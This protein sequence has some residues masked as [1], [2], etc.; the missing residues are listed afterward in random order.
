VD[1]GDGTERGDEG[2]E[3]KMTVQTLD[4]IH[5]KGYRLRNITATNRNGMTS[6]PVG[7]ALFERRGAFF[8]SIIYERFGTFLYATPEKQ[9]REV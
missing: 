4:D 3:R 9:E 6:E 1:A 8:E 5:N 2:R 7:I